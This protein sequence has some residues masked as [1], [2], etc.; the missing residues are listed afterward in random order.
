MAEAVVAEAVVAA[1]AAVAAVAEVAEVA[2][3]AV[4]AVAAV[5]AA[6]PIVKFTFET[7]KKMLP[8][9]SIFT[10]AVVVNEFG[11][12]TASEPSFAVLAA[13]TVGYVSPPSVDRLIF[14]LAVLIGA[15]SVLALF[16]VIVCGEPGR[17]RDRRVRRGDEERAGVGGERQ[18]RVRAVVAA[19]AHPPVA[20][21]EAEVQRRRRGGE[22][23]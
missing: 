20:G 14:T 3:V 16:H 23:T 2:E 18:R 22:P 21:R 17:I 15:M 13:S 6:P 9:A 4:A 7:S 10:R 8:T 11:I 12:M 1:V 19:A 5:A